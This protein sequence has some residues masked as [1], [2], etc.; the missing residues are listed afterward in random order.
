[1][2]H[3][4]AEPPFLAQQPHAPVHLRPQ[5]LRRLGAV[6]AAGKCQNVRDPWKNDYVYLY[7]GQVHPES[8]DVK[9]YGADGMVVKPGRRQVVVRADVWAESDGA[10]PVLA[11]V[12]QALQQLVQVLGLGQVLV[13]ALFGPGRGS[14]GGAPC[15]RCSRRAW[16]R[17]CASRCG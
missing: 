7:P 16:A 6:V 15:S 2:R 13:Q 11:A 4:E 5:R 10:E 1:M 14:P 17:S 8:F 12:A 3:I 9:S